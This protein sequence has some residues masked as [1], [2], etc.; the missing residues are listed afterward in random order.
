MGRNWEAK[1]MGRMVICM[2]VYYATVI[3]C[4][5]LG[6]LNPSLWIL[7][8]APGALIGAIP[9]VYL[10][11]L[12]RYAGMFTLL[13]VFWLIIL[14]IGTNLHLPADVI[15]CLIISIVADVIFIVTR[16]EGRQKRIRCSYPIFSLMTLTPILAL[17]GDR[18]AYLIQIKDKMGSTVFTGGVH[19]WANLPGLI[20]VF[21]I[22]S[23]FGL[24]GVVIAESVWETTISNKQ[25]DTNSRR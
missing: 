15:Y 24:A 16:K 9:V 19:A 18:D 3:G 12:R 22:V 1:V 25:N 7:A 14:K 4:R 21:V 5:S 23:V 10:L 11:Y 13:T 8:S 17:W 20:W 2:I 6:F